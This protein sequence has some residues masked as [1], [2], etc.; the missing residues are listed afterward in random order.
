MFIGHFGVAFAAKKVAPK[1][2][3]GVLFMACQFMDLIW[4]ALV[5]LGIEKVSVE[6]HATAFNSINFEY[7][8]FTHSLVG[9]ILLSMIFRWLYY[10]FTKDRR[11][12]WI[13]SAVVLSHWVLDWIVHKPDL[14]LSI[15]NTHPMGLGLW[16]SVIGT[17]I[18]ESALFFG[19][20]YLYQQTTKPATPAKRWGLWG[21][22]AFLTLIYVLNVWG[23]QPEVGMPGTAI[24]GPALAMWILVPWAWWVDSRA[25]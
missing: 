11:S 15:N 8:P 24:A 9:A 1:I 23:P 3:L 22:L 6:P 10:A 4:P 21:L 2:S 13:V 20:Y 19:G 25:A 7:Y 5:L 12:S 16:N 14:P 18:V 17:V